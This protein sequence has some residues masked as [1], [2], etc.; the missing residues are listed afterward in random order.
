MAKHSMSLSLCNLRYDI[1][2]INDCSDA[3]HDRME[4]GYSSKNCI[5]IEQSVCQCDVLEVTWQIFFA[6]MTYTI[7][8]MH[9]RRFVFKALFF[10]RRF[11]CGVK[12]SHTVSLPE[13][14]LVFCKAKKLNSG[15][16][17]WLQIVNVRVRRVWKGRLVHHDSNMFSNKQMF[18][19]G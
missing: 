2:D 15:E 17:K 13:L 1:N 3:A 18:V 8:C 9:C 12:S 4:K 16:D 10:F 6:W 14:P 5:R 11:R 7:Y 19:C